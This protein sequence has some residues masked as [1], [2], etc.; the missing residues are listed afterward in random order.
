M[1]KLH[2]TWKALPVDLL[3][4]FAAIKNHFKYNNIVDF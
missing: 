1:K 2:K 3:L 4:F